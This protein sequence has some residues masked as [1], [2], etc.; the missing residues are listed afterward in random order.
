MVHSLLDFVMVYKCEDASQI[1]T[2]KDVWGQIVLLVLE[3]IVVFNIYL[4]PTEAIILILNQ[5]ILQ[6]ESKRNLKKRINLNL[7]LKL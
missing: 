6:W 1:L 3:L 4:I 7:C 2:D 5:E